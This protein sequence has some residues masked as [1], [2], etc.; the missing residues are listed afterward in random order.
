[1]QPVCPFVYSA[2]PP[3]DVSG[4][5]FGVAITQLFQTVMLELSR[6][7]RRNKGHWPSGHSAFDTVQHCALPTGGG[8]FLSMCVIHAHCA[9]VALGVILKELNRFT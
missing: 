6:D 2:G 9:R 8:H 1:M 7:D 5:V 3:G 4:T